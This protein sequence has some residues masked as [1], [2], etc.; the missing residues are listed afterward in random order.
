METLISMVSDLSIILFD[1]CLYMQLTL[2]KK[3]TRFHRGLMYGGAA[4]IAVLY[5]VVAYIFHVPYAAASFLC[6]TVPSFL[7]FLW[8]SK[9]KTA[10]F[11]VTFCFVDTVTFIIAA[12]SKFFLVLG[13][14]TGGLISCLFLLVVCTVT[15]FLLKPYCP[16]YRELLDQVA[17]GWTPMA[18]STVLIYVL[19]IFTAAYPAPLLSRIEYLPVYLLI[20]FTVLSFYAVF[21]VLIL[22]KAQLAKA[23]ILLQQ[24]KHWHDLAYMDNLTQLANSAAYKARTEELEKDAPS[25]R[26][27]YVLIF[28]IDDF[29]Q[30]N[31]TYGHHIGN[32]VLQKTAQF[33]LNDFSRKHYE[34]F[35]VGG[36]EFAAIAK[37]LSPQQVDAR[38]EQIN[39]MPF[40]KELGCTYSCGFSPIDFSQD[41]AFEQAFIKADQEMYL[42]KSAKK[43]NK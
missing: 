10:R 27:I 29:K 22:Q 17:T 24:Q 34:F 39:Q 8:L 23:N 35:R 33:F 15:F 21:I 19:L 25:D 38:V 18:I 14:M 7:F 41:H 12:I 16:K 36:D 1:L 30:V 11:L 9:Y 32:V 26:N 20:C 37:D 40:K 13:G 4:F 43:K 31:D 6:M 5:V 3:D 42:V 28:D 2:L